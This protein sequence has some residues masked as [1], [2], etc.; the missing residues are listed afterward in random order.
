MGTKEGRTPF[1]D[2]RF[3]DEDMERE[4][5][6]ERGEVHNYLDDRES[7]QDELS[8]LIFWEDYEGASLLVKEWYRRSN[9]DA[10]DT[11]DE[12]ASQVA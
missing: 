3:P 9:A 2:I 10:A 1:E 4:F 8:S 7:Y 11:L 5:A 6:K 12:R